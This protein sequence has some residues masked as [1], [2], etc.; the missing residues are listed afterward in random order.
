M[1]APFT[2]RRFSPVLALSRAA[3]TRLR[4]RAVGTGRRVLALTVL[5]IALGG[6]AAVALLAQSGGPP[7]TAFASA[8]SGQY[9]VVAR[10]IGG[11]TLVTVVGTGAN[12]A[13]MEI[14]TVPH[15]YGFNLRGA[16][17]PGGRQVALI[18]PDGGIAARPVAS[19][20]TL[21]LETGELRRLAE[22][23]EPLQDALWT[24]DSG[25]V[26]VTRNVRTETETETRALAVAVVQV[27][28]EGVATVL[29]M[30]QGAVTVAPL[31]FD[32][33]GRL[34][35]V[36]LDARGS[37]LT[38]AGTAI[39]WLSTHV[40]RDWALSPD[41][42][43]VAFVEVNLWDGVRYLPRVVSIE[44][45]GGVSAA[46]TSTQQAL[47]AAWAPSGDTPRFGRE[48]YT[49]PGSVSAQ[50]MSGFD[51]PLGYSRD[52]G[53]LAVRHWNGWS[54]A[55]PGTPRLEIVSSVG[56]QLLEGFTRFFGWS[57]R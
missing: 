35:A 53:S 9:A 43:Q 49:P 10:N 47:G 52:G 1:N 50:G 17:S 18:A 31:G 29:E 30:H 57:A 39:R 48:P 3:G 8:P 38:R 45:G 19:L 51:V 6:V 33:E 27:D 41:G 5:T 23:L 28:L 13:P 2:F 46:S 21:D 25:A 42:A 26:L 4:G 20:L 22:G 12:D 15:L 14:A 7:R 44:G 37:T 56:R 54:F 36:R 32:G 24:P 40:T 11:A 16:V 34:L 55:E